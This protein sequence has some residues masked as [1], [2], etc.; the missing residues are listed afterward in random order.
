MRR[1]DAY[2]GANE[3]NAVRFSR[4]FLVIAICFKTD[5]HNHRR[6]NICRDYTKAESVGEDS[7]H[8]TRL[9]SDRLVVRFKHRKDK[10]ETILSS[11]LY[12]VWTFV[13]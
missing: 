4:F 11:I 2:T 1:R 13:V 10:D 3:N 5:S 6:T 7:R 12:D 8:K 9:K